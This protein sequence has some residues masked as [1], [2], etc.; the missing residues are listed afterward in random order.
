MKQP[1]LVFQKGTNYV[2]FVHFLVCCASRV[3]T[4]TGFSFSLSRC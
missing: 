1:L 4:L 2:V 3:K